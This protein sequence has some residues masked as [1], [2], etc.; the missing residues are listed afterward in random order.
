MPS[1]NRQPI[2]KDAGGYFNEG[3]LYYPS[4]WHKYC[5]IVG[6]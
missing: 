3:V 2:K 5:R 4:T 6:I 1:L